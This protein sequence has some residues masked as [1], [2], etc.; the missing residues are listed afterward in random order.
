M[1][2]YALIREQILHVATSRHFNLLETLA[3]NLVKILSADQ[4]VMSL[5]LEIHKPKAFAD[6]ESA[7]IEI[8]YHRS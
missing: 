6:A 1:V 3:D 2:D 7:G 4:R 8:Q 5:R